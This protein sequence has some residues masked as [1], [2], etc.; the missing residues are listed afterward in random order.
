[1]TNVELRLTKEPEACL[2]GSGILAAV[3]AGIFPDIPSAIR[4]MVH[5]ERTVLPNPEAHLQYKKLLERY[6]MVYPALKPLF[7]QVRYT[8]KSEIHS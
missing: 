3:G 2:L 7:H 8:V 1:M 4:A 5:V 6:R